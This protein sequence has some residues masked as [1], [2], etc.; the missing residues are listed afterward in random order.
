MQLAEHTANLF[1]TVKEYFIVYC[2]CREAV[3]LFLL[4]LSPNSL[5]KTCNNI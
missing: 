3:K 5:I 2:G 1:M 4:L